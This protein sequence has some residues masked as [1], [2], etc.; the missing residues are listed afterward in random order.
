MRK[1]IICKLKK[2]YLS[3]AICAFIG[4]STPVTGSELVHQFVN[5]SFGGNPG[6]SSHLL[7]LAA[8]QN[9]FQEDGQDQGTALDEFNDR[10]QRSL[11]GRITSAVSQEIVDRDG[12]ITP[13]VFDTI[14]YTINVIDEGDGL[15]TIETIDKLTGDVTVIQV[16][17]D[18]S[19]E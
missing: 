10:L 1:M 18:V 8:I 12:N 7:G 14:D 9:Q 15:I 13:G 6:N 19:S 5:P 2:Q 3:V 17:N 16:Q 4:I 11:L